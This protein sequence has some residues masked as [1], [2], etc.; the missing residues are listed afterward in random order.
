ME[1]LNQLQQLM[2]L[3]QQMQSRLAEIQE[4][5]EKETFSASAGGGIVEVTADGKGGVRSLR[6]DPSAVDVEDLEM[7]EDLIL[8]AI[9]QAQG[10]ARERLEAEMRQATGGMPLPDLGS[11]LGG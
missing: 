10:K 5:L 6:I 4:R 11:L 8:A 3:G 7:L 1:N 2:Q 9:S